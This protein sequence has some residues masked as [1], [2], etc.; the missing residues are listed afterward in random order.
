MLENLKNIDWK[1]TL[2]TLFLSLLIVTAIGVYFDY[3]FD[4]IVSFYFPINFL[5]LIDIVFFIIIFYLNQAEWDIKIRSLS[6]FSTIEKTSRFIFLFGLLIIILINI[7]GSFLQWQS[8]AIISNIL[9]FIT[10]VKG[11]QDLFILISI[12][13][14]LFTFFINKHKIYVEGK[15]ERKSEEKMSKK[16]EKEFAK[17]FVG[18]NRIPVVRNIF[19]WMYIEGW[20]YSLG[21]LAIFF[22][23]LILR[24]WN[25]GKLSFWVDETQSIVAAKN[26]I[27]V[28][29]PYYMENLIY[30]RAFIYTLLNTLTILIIGLDEFTIRLIPVIFS[31]LTLVFIYILLKQAINKKTALLGSLIY[32]I[33][34][35]SLLYARF[36]RFYIA[37]S[38]FV[39]LNI[40]LFY[41]GFVKENRRF[42]KLLIFTT[43]LMLGF[44]AKS[45]VIVSILISFL[46]INIYK[47]DLLKKKKFLYKLKLLLKDKLL[48]LYI[49]LS[50]IAFYLF[51]YLDK[52][53]TLT[54][55]FI[56]TFRE[57]KY[58][59][60]LPLPYFVKELIYPKWD[61]FF[62]SF[63]SE[64][65]LIIFIGFIILSAIL[66]IKILDSR[67]QLSLKD[68]LTYYLLTNLIFLSIYTVNVKWFH[69]DQRHF[70]F[71]FPLLII[72]FSIFVKIF[73]DILKFNKVL[74]FLLI[75]LLIV[76]VSPIEGIRNVIYMDYGYKLIGTRYNIMSAEPYR[77]D[78]KTPYE[79]INSSSSKEDVVLV[80]YFGG[81]GFLNIYLDPD[82]N[83]SFFDKDG[84]DLAKIVNSYPN[85]RVWVIDITYDMDKSHAKY[86]WGKS[87]YF[88]ENHKENIVYY[89]LDKK[90]RVFLF[91]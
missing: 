3:F 4:N 19:K 48:V 50:S 85:N 87:Y 58:S 77:S 79:F 88:M 46:L 91:D 82:I 60:N 18:V 71:L 17:N 1:K 20:G 66:L 5:Y 73:I 63:I 64:Y 52:T 34:D 23:G 15:L 67:R 90:T 41:F 65:Y 38:F 69:W 42:K 56:R 35:Y 84:D 59:I 44:D 54:G 86:R 45:I 7:E 12:I 76:I 40:Y 16:R 22:L 70:S 53:N 74:N 89:G 39:L 36:N 8:N 30:L 9:L 6:Y 80:S 11:F 28:G 57:E 32:A 26:L 51:N 81:N 13:S 43:A 29:I 68:L 24:I 25:L 55:E 83:Y 27:E 10:L 2:L 14:G 31:L 61:N 37:Q 49:L 62:F 33:S 47:K 21:I 75:V 78:Y 72:N